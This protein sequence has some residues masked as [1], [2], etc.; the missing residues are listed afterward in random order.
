MVLHILSGSS[1]S[2]YYFACGGVKEREKIAL[3]LKRGKI[4]L[5]E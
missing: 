2:F 4:I 5:R 1:I 3:A